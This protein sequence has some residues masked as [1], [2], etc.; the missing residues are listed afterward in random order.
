MLLDEVTSDYRLLQLS[1]Q[2]CT[3]AI[4]FSQMN[5]DGRDI[6]DGMNDRDIDLLRSIVRASV[7]YPLCDK[8]VIKSYKLKLQKLQF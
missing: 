7:L 5:K 1:I 6:L 8:E 4:H 3:M 2:S